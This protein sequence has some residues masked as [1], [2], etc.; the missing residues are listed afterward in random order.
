MTVSV[1]RATPEDIPLIAGFNLAMARESESRTLHADRLEKGVRHVLLEPDDGFYLVAEVDGEA[2]GSLLVT[3]E[4]SDWRNGCFWWIQS[5]YVLP[6]FRRRGVYSRMH[7]EVR[8]AALADRRACG[9]RLYVEKG[10]T[11]AQA[12][13]GHLGMSETDYRLYEEEFGQDPRHG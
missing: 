8:E 7:A 12:T 11:G 10:N 4:W 6:R 9:L 5:V 1:R 3:F 2:A 13:Y